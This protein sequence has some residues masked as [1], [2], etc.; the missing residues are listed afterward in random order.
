MADEASYPGVYIDESSAGHSIAGVAT[1]ITAFLGRAAKG[2]TDQ[3][4]SVF[5]LADFIDHYGA[6]DLNY[7]MGFAV[8]DFFANGG[9]HAVIGRLYKDPPAGNAAA[10]LNAGS[11]DAVALVASSPGDWANNLEAQVKHDGDQAV[12]TGLGLAPD[13]LF[14]L[15]V[16]AQPGGPLEKFLNLT[17]KDSPRRI[18]RV[19]ARES[20]LARIA[21]AGALLVRPG[22]SVDSAGNAIWDRV[23]PSDIGHAGAPLDIA[24]YAGDRAARTGKYLLEHA[25]LVNVMCV[26]ANALNDSVPPSVYAD[27]LGYCVERRAFLLVDPPSD[28]TRDSFANRLAEFPFPGTAARNAAIF[29]P[30][31]MQ[32]NPLR[33][34]QIEPFAV[35]GAVAGVIARTDATWGVWKAP[36]GTHASLAGV[37]GMAEDLSDA[38]SGPLNQNGINVIRNFTGI[39]PVLWGARTMRGGDAYADEYKY[40][41]VRRTA[42]FIEESLQRGLQWVVLE[43]NDE[44]LWAQIRLTAG[45]FLNGLF[46]KGAFQGQTP[47][48]A[49]FVKCDSE[50]TTTGDIANGVV[51]LVVGFAPLKPAE[52][53]ILQLHLTA[54]QKGPP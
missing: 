47:R 7:P 6:L 20:A 24:D 48:D 38:Q 1:S 44:T 39:G 41:P 31:P 26:S 40:I 25:D 18:D 19:L 45:A 53:V 30:R 2:P 35:C 13:D 29:Y 28:W 34:N 37:A 54:G 36:A 23:Q 33:G 22:E 8:R 10:A 51:N 15:R 4:V 27:I 14:S 52:F 43:P 5:D 16:R 21:D 17:V 49:N 9:S 50:T 12:A 3:P 42:L 32:A 11:V 46:R